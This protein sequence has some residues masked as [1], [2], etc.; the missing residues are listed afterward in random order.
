MT[1]GLLAVALRLLARKNAAI[2]RRAKYGKARS[3]RRCADTGGAAEAEKTEALIAD[4]VGAQDVAVHD[5]RRRALHIVHDRIVE[6]RGSGR[7]REPF[8]EQKI[9]IAALQIDGRSRCREPGERVCHAGGERL[10]QLIV[11]EPRIE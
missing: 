4:V 5:E 6:E 7:M 8:A 9:A 1:S 10:A 3:R 2:P 11:A